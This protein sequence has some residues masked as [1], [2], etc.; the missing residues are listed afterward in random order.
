MLA[1]LIALFI[2]V[3][4][5]LGGMVVLWQHALQAR[6]ELSQAQIQL[7]DTIEALPA[8]V[9]IFDAQDRLIAYNRQLVEVLPHLAD[10]LDK[11]LSFGE[12]LKFAVERGAIPGVGPDDIAAE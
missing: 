11:Q 4:L 10:V 6:A 5:L 3:L 2:V 1:L 7:N 12:L 9:E 8:S